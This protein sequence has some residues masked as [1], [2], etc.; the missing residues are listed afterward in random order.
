MVT[1]APERGELWRHAKVARALGSPFVA[2]VLEAGERQLAR[3]PR[4]A[5]LIR[6]WP[7]DTSQDAVAMRF[8]AA[9][10]S[11]ARHGRLPALSALYANRH[12]DFDGAIGGAMSEQ[13]DVIALSMR[14]APQTNEVGRSAAIAAALM[15]ARHQFGLPFELLEIGSSCGLNLN[16]GH[17]EYELGGVSAGVIG[18]SV[19]IAPTWSGGSPPRAPIEVVAARGTDLNPL[20]ADDPRTRD[21]LLSYVWADQP[22]R[23]RRLESALALALRHPPH[24]DHA[25]A[26][27]WLSARLKDVQAAGQCR[28]IFHSMVLQYL[29]EHNRH[30]ITSTIRQAGARATAG[31]PLAWISFE[32]TA[33]RDEVQLCLTC[34]PGG[35]TCLLATCH[36]YGEWID[37]RM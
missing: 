30:T 36:A 15:V 13:D 3:A 31:R 7:G 9:L 24:I 25:D 5:A 16:L 28:V 37:W 4:T 32:W 23:A 19:Q 6:N 11:L 22:H 17:Y 10:H 2:A 34:W 20:N 33:I 18:S 8:N 35:Q 12:E 14:D 1:C 29:T 26:V 27:T 21:R